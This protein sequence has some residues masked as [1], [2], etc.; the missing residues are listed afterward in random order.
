[1]T[2]SQDVLATVRSAL[3]SE[4]RVHP[5]DGPLHLAFS[6]GDLTIEGEVDTLDFG[7][8][9]RGS[10]KRVVR[11]GVGV[12]WPRAPPPEHQQRGYASR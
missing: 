11:G 3:H 10:R 9:V 4:P 8:V 7:G 2:D 12:G 1:M 6:N 5:I